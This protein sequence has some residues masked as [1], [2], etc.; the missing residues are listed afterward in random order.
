MFKKLKKVLALI[1]LTAVA[2]S[3]AGCKNKETDTKE[4]AN[5]KDIKIGVMA[6]T[7]PIAQI[8]KEGMKEKGYNI[9][10]VTYDGNHLPATALKDN[11]ID[12]VILNH[13]PWIQ[14]F[15]KENDCN[16]TMVQ[17]YLYYAPTNM[18]SEKYKSVEEIPNNAQIT[19]QGDPANMD[20]NLKFLEKAGLLKLG[21]K[22]GEFYTTLDIK[23]NPKNLT[24]VE[25]EI[26]AVPRSYKDVD[27]IISGATIAIK[28]GVPKDDVIMEDPTSKDYQLGLIVRN[29]E[30]T[31]E[32]VKECYEVFATQDF[33]DKFNKEY[34]G[35]YILYDQE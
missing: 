18:Y 23:E 33:K 27:A 17:P 32:W 25:A 35:A 10:I 24:L 12:G 6:I 4:D 8:L 1:T 34:D 2:M 14:K 31:A 15:N 28:G 3:F 16:L 29:D 21:E 7:E 20:R 22:S 13:N 19:I 9:D 30:E 26:T 5:K 11:S